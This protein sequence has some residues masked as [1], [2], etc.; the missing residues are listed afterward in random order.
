MIDHERAQNSLGLDIFL[1]D[2]L[3]KPIE[4]TGQVL[5][6]VEVVF[7]DLDLSCGTTFLCRTEEEPVGFGRVGEAALAREQHV[8]GAVEGMHHLVPKE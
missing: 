8:G 2:S 6:F 1:F 3:L 7:A 4:C 5:G